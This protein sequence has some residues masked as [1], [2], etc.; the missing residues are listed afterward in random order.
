[1]RNRKGVSGSNLVSSKTVAKLYRDMVDKVESGNEKHVNCYTCENCKHKIKTSYQDKG[2]I[3]EALECEKC[4]KKM[5]G[6]GDVDIYPEMEATWSWYRPTFS[7]CLKMRTNSKAPILNHV[8]KGGL[9]M[10]NL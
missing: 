8:L 6:S 10:K 9:L 5:V 1:M 3:P 4:H 7:Q 2:G